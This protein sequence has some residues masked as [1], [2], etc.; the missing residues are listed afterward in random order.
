MQVGFG[1]Y[2]R[3]VLEPRWLRCAED[4]STERASAAGDRKRIQRIT[5]FFRSLPFFSSRNCSRVLALTFTMRPCLSQLLGTSWAAWARGDP[6][7]VAKRTTGR[8]TGRMARMTATEFYIEG[9]RPQPRRSFS[10][11]LSPY[12]SPNVERLPVLCKPD[13]F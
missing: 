7:L 4:E 10:E 13:H 2:L 9:L 5:D 1:S 6:L 12:V 3:T 8:N 11:V